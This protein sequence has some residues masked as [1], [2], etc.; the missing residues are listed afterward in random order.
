M[1]ARYGETEMQLMDTVWRVWRTVTI[2]MTKWEADGDEMYI[3]GWL[4]ES[5]T[6]DTM[7]NGMIAEYWEQHG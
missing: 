7:T 3:I 2:D 4:N 5:Q 6:D 1:D